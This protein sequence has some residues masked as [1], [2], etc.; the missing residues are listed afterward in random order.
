MFGNQMA[1]WRSKLLMSFCAG[2]K[3]LLNAQHT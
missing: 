2:I 3:Y 1:D